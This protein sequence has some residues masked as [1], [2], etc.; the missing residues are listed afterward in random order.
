MSEDKVETIDAKTVMHCLGE[1]T[2]KL[3]QMEKN[4]SRVTLALIG[5]IA[6][7]IGVKVLG[8][9]VLLD[10]A[11]ALAIIGV[12]LLMGALVFKMRIRKFGS[13]LSRTGKFLLLMMGCI[14]LTQIAV[15]FRDMHYLDANIIYFIRILQNIS[16]LVFAWILISDGHIYKGFKKNIDQD[17]IYKDSKCDAEKTYK[18]A[19]DS[20]EEIYQGNTPPSEDIHDKDDGK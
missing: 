3:E 9:P 20:A 11:T 7:Q 15:Y 18:K 14:T 1:L 10:I 6:A 5:V 17:A 16:I 12:V 13:P 2:G 8:T 4:Q 19:M